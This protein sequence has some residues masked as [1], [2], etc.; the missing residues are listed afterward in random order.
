MN[1]FTFCI[2]TDFEYLKSMPV[3]LTRMDFHINL[4]FGILIWN[5]VDLYY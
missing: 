3:K 1:L 2:C 4:Y 5:S